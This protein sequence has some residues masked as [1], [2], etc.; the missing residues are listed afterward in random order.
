MM[1]S[2][3]L[4]DSRAEVQSWAAVAAVL[5]KLRGMTTEQA[6]AEVLRMKGRS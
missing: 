3:S 1:E 6:V 4:V 5:V 2:R